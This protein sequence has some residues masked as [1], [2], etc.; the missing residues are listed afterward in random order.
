MVRAAE[1]LV[2]RHDFS[3][4]RNAGSVPG[5][6]VRRIDRL[7]IE[8]RGEYIALDVVGDGFLYKMVRNLVGTLLLVGRGKL[9]PEE[10][11]EILERRDRRAA[12]PTAPAKGLCLVEVLY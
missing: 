9:R 6:A 12:G 7:D 11:G 5:P 4:F 1:R 3:S 8:R 10:V 2:G